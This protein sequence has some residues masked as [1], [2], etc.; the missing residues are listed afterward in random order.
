MP[1]KSDGERRE[2]C[3]AFIRREFHEYENIIYNAASHARDLAAFVDAECERE[4]EAACKAVCQSCRLG[5]PFSERN[6]EWHE[7]PC[8]GKNCMNS[9]SKCAA[10]PIR[11]GSRP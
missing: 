9:G 8:R 10:A 5:H 11:E 4:R 7:C 6:P 2:R 3:E 1:A